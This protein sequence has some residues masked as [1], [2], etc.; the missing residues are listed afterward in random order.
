MSKRDYVLI[1]GSVY[2]TLQIA[3]ML[4]GN[5]IKKQAK[6]E[7]VRLVAHD[8]AGSLQGDNPNFDQDKFLSACG[9]S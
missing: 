5:Q 7:T 1:A 6:R 3:E 8:L 9:V 4:E 2:R